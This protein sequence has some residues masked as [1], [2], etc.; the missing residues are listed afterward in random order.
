M[1]SSVDKVSR[2]ATWLLEKVAMAHSSGSVGHSSFKSPTSRERSLVAL[3]KISVKQEERSGRLEL[4]RSQLKDSV[5][6][7]SGLGGFVSGL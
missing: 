1:K 5:F 2:P 3:E 6:G 7:K 4:S